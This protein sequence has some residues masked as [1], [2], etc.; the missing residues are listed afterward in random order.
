MISRELLVIPYFD[1]L[2]EFTENMVL[3]TEATIRTDQRRFRRFPLR[4]L[5]SVCRP[6][7]LLRRCK[8][9]PCRL[10]DVSLGGMALL[11][12]ETVPARLKTAL[13]QHARLSIKI[14]MPSGDIYECKG[15][16][17]HYSGN[18]VGV[19]L[20]ETPEDLQKILLHQS[21]KHC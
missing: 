9:V 17:R 16:V 13:A 8:P 10:L 11:L 2:H 6:G 21:L 19:E 3:E 7:K 15:V 12:D 18:T 5:I 1:E 20:I 4:A 14:I